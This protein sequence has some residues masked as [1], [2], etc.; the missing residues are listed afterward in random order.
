MRH[1]WIAVL[2]IL[3][4]ALGW[5][6]QHPPKLPVVPASASQSEEWALPDAPGRTIP[7]ILKRLDQHSPWG[8]K[9]V[10]GN[11]APLTPPN[12]RITGVV[13]DGA[14]HFAL[15]QIQG[16]PITQLRP[17]DLLPG[18][19]KII[20]VQQDSL[21]ILLNGKVRSLRIYRE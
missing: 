9:P 8:I 13:Q 14:N 21:C 5:R 19:A 2:A 16:Q 17:G 10:A 18:G 15:L 7:D 1:L 11:E 4:A 3:V 6:W 12:W 20:A